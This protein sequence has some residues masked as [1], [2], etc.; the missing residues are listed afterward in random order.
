MANTLRKLAIDFGNSYI[1]V[2][3]EDKKGVIRKAC[4]PSTFGEI[5]NTKIVK[6][7]VVKFGD[8]ILQLGKS[9]GDE[10]TNVKKAE[11]EYL[12][13]QILWAA[14]STLGAGEHYVKLASGLP[15]MDYT[16][17]AGDKEE[18]QH[19]LETLRCIAGEVNEE[20]ISVNIVSPVNI[21]PEGYS[22]VDVLVDILPKDKKTL[23]MDIGMKSSDYALVEFNE[24]EGIFEPIAY[25]TVRKGLDSIYAPV[26]EKLKNKG[27]TIKATELDALY[28]KGNTI[29]L[30][31]K[32]EFEVVEH[33][34][35]TVPQCKSILKE[36][37]NDPAI[38]DLTPYAKALV[39][40]GAK[41]L[42]DIMSTDSFTNVLSITEELKYY[43]NALGY[44]EALA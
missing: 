34:L 2:V 16:N 31:D 8:L 12:E 40:G 22:A 36:I 6:K 43:A 5:Q 14:Y 7:N 9:G 33:V 38:G 20:K 35:K 23:V 44:F 29:T 30:G 37:S 1:N 26:L 18:F 28:R 19:H 15:L 25:G 4:I 32:S 17:D 27:V 39:G 11:R 21:G 3:G 41:A 24:E 13:H 42:E 10:F